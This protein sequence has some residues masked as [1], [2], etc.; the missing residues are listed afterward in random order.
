MLNVRDSVNGGNQIKSKAM[1]RAIFIF[2]TLKQDLT[3]FRI[4]NVVEKLN[5]R[6][7]CRAESSVRAWLGGE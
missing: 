2:H 6:G 7:V 5:S 4:R 3:S 1:I